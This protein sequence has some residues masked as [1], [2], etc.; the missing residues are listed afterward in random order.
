MLFAF[1]KVNKFSQ[2]PNEFA[3]ND[4]IA[5]LHVYPYII[6]CALESVYFERECLCV[7]GGGRRV[8]VCVCAGR[9]GVVERC[10]LL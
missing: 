1:A 9:K 3:R 6:L 8:W 5:C 2:D 4:I 7:C 10:M